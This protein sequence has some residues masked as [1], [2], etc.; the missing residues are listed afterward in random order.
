MAAVEANVSNLLNTF[1]GEHSTLY[2]VNGWLTL[3]EPINHD[4]SSIVAFELPNDLL[5]TILIIPFHCT[6]EDGINLWVESQLYCIIK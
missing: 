2:A 1:N 5:N 6:Y 3:P 4:Q